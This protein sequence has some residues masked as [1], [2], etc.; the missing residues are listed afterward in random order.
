MGEYPCV[1]E[2]LF[3]LPSISA[4]LVYQTILSKVKDESATVLDLGCC[5][6][7]DLR[8]LAADGAPSENMYA[9]DLHPELWDIGY[10]LFRDRDAIKA[11]F[12]Q[13]DILDPD[14]PLQTLNGKIDIIIACQFLHLFS[15]EG[16]RVALKKM[17]GMSRPGSCFV[18]YQIGRE[19]P[20]EVQTP[21][22]V[23]YYHDVDSFN[24]L[25]G[26]VMEDSGTEWKMDVE[27]V[28]LTQW[29]MEKE[30]FEWM[31]PDSRGLN[32]V[33]TRSDERTEDSHL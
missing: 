12:I 3:L 23:M 29:G 6:G 14:S 8:R 24:K 10:D 33:I 31:S 1:G 26:E 17:V 22:G 2:W 21:W 9:S 13:A 18:G 4:F 28:D 25:W 11:H 19:N 30:D 32:F 7:Q 15:W 20:A 27:L 5:L 16:Q